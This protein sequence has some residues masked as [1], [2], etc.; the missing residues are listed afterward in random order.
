MLDTIKKD[1]AKKAFNIYNKFVITIGYNANRIHQHFEIIDSIN[2]QELE[3]KYPIIHDQITFFN[4]SLAMR[5]SDQKITQN[6]ILIS[7]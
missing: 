4:T 7:F 6:F 3:T 1:D 5:D 2:M